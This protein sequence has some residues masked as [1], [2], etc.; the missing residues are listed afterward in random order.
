MNST[1]EKGLMYDKIEWF[2]ESTSFKNKEND[3]ESC[4]MVSI[5]VRSWL[6]MV[7]LMKT[8]RV[9]FAF[10]IQKGRYGSAYE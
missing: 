4:K 10:P 5:Y 1:L 2:V 9:D 6:E 8:R 3:T 7:D